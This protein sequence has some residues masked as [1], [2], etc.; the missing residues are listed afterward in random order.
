MRQPSRE[1]MVHD[2]PRCSHA[3]AASLLGGIVLGS[4][5]ALGCV[6][7]V[8]ADDAIGGDMVVT[9]GMKPWE[10]CGEC[11]DLNGV[12]PNGHFPNLAAQKA[13]YIRK[14]MTDF[15]DG[16]RTNDHGQ[17]STSAQEATGT[18][19]DRVVAYFAGL[20]PPPPV[21]LHDVVPA[22]AARAALLVEHGSRP[23]KIPPCRDCHSAHPK[24]A[25]DA[26]RLEAQQPAYLI[27]ELED[28]RS[29]RRTNDPDRAMRRVASALS[30]DDIAA[31]AAY[32]AS[33]PRL[34]PDIGRVAG[35]ESAR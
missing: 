14:E 25:F 32:L 9:K 26:P 17:M 16:R 19:L 33:L 7:S 27:K 8:V 18:T 5:L 11:H 2:D 22:A 10:G 4:A 23:D 6:G 24:H 21:P 28:F 1:L 34:A 31:L 3:R 15:A 20:P 30:N 13:S 29:G 35:P 12:A